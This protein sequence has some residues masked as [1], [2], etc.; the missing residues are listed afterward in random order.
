MT[1]EK[2]QVLIIDDH[3]MVREGLSLRINREHDL[4]ACYESENAEQA[5][6][7]C[8]TNRVDIALVDLRLTEYSGL[9][10]IKQL[11]H[12]FPAIHILTIS[13][14]DENLYAERALKAG[15]QGYIMKHEAMDTLIH[16]IR[17]ILKG[18][19]YVSDALRT[20]LIRQFLEKGD[21]DS[22]ISQL[23]SMEFDVLNLIGQGFSNR[24]IANQFNRSPKTIE[25]HCANIKKKLGLQ[26]G[27]EL[28][29]YAIEWFRM[30]QETAIDQIQ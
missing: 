1:P 23:S 24:D 11:R 20:Q 26:N 9:T 19:L 21:E 27:R 12:R 30:D 7:Y 22:P 15:A 2:K 6:N 25:A 5:I 3:P 28:T 29:Q 10:L 18:H 16:A 8:M 4:E 14:Y 17:L 13:M